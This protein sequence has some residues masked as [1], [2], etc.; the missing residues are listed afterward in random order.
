MSDYK[1]AYSD[2]SKDYIDRS[3][4]SNSVDLSRYERSKARKAQYND[5]WMKQ[6]SKP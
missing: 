4:P 1:T 3:V 2:I 5:E 6:K